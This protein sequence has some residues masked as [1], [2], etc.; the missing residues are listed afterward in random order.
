M[1]VGRAVVGLLYA[2]LASYGL[3]CLPR[4]QGAVEGQFLREKD[5]NH[6]RIQ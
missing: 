6:A 5:C 1:E 2:V 4:S 3:A